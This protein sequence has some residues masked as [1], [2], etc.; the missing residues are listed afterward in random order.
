MID[1]GLHPE[2][3]IPDHY[4]PE[5]TSTVWK[6]PYQ[7]RA[8]E[9]RKWAEKHNIPPAVDD[10]LKIA[11]LGIDIQNSFCIP[12]FE[13]FVAGQSGTGAMDDTR[14]L[15]EFVYRNLGRITQITLTLDSHLAMQ[16]FHPVFLVDEHGNHPDPFTLVTR[17]DVRTGR[18]R[19]NPAITHNLSMDNAFAQR[20]LLH[21]TEMLESEGKYNLTIWPYHCMIGSVGHALV[22]SF[23]EAVFFH[24]IARYSQ[25]TFEAKGL[26][27]LT[28]HYSAL[29]PEVLYGPDG[30]AIATS[31]DRILQQLRR[32]DAVVV[33]GQAKSHCVAWT[34]DDL[35]EKIQ[36]VDPR[37]VQKV[38]LLEDCTSPVVIPGAA[39]YTGLADEAFERF[40]REGMNIV[41]STDPIEDWLNTPRD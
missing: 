10:R 5:M 17:M 12:D 40:A 19:I 9:A 26:N 21:Y 35:L 24:S 18:W 38:Y 34:I 31:D 6:V 27:P 32:F 28:E 41:R 39:D 1:P 36:R 16:I 25:P 30:E 4:D 23:E 8:T 14:R 15:C 3:P 11:L 2:L 33:A 20:Y 22:S 29:G 37:L 13:L 7:Q